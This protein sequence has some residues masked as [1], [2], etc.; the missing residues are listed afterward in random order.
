VPNIE[1][2][3]KLVQLVARQLGL[4]HPVIDRIVDLVDTRLHANREAGEEVAAARYIARPFPGE[5]DDRI[6]CRRVETVARLAEAWRESA[7]SIAAPLEDLCRTPRRLRRAG[8]RGARE[9]LVRPRGAAA[10]EV[11]RPLARGRAHACGAAAAARVASPADARGTH[12]NVRLIEA[13]VALRLA[14]DV[15]PGAGRRRFAREAG[16]LVDAMACRSRSSTRAGAGAHAPALLK[17]AD[18][19]SHGALVLGEWKPYAA[20]DW[21]QQDC[22][23][24]IGGAAAQLPG[25]AFAGRSGVAAAD[26][27]AAR[28]APGRDGAARHGRHH[29]HVVRHAGGAARRQ[30]RAEFE[31]IGDAEVQL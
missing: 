31:G 16:S 4:R 26:V 19:Q 11:R 14:R 2:A 6:R 3:D 13:E 12:F 5:P 21:S 20:R 7:P 17:L 30:V 25:H 1:R 18:L 24:R 22:V 10:L 23:V 9:R 8:A 15:T 29:R 28:D 27:A